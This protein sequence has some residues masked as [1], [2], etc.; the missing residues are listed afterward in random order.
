[1]KEHFSPQPDTLEYLNYVAS[2]Y[3][4]RRDMTFNARATA[5]VFDDEANC[6]TVTFEDGRQVRGTLL[7]TGLGVLSAPT[8]PNVPGRDDFQGQ[9]FH[10]ARWP[11]EP[12]SFEGKRVGVIGT[13]ATAIQ[14]IPEIAKTAGNLS[15]FQRHPNWAAPLHNSKITPEEQ[16]DIKSRYDEIYARCW[17]TVGCFIHTPD[18]RSAL[19][20]T[21]EEREAF[22]EK[23]YSEPGFGIWIGNYRDVLTDESANALATEF[24]SRKIKERVDDPVIA[25]KLIP[26][27]HGFGLRRLPLESGYFEAYNRPN[28]RLVDVLENPIERITP[29][30]V[31]TTVE[32]HEL[33]IL[34]YATGFDGVTGGYDL[35]DIQGLGGGGSRTT[36]RTICQRP[37]SAS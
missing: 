30:G 32:E 28:V 13:G 12:V 17:E 5:A 27:N 35:I 20:V 36:G 25:E 34:V 24:M 10:T 6:W 9:A 19:D 7:I 23:L 31:Q 3:D 29:K 18:P 16:K 22:W 11:H 2:K 15:V 14:A 26:K 37:F 33:D 8:L 1:M 4:L 21:P